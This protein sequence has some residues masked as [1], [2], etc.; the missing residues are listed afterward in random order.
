M[1][2]FT[3]SNLLRW[4]KKRNKTKMLRL[5]WNLSCNIRSTHEHHNPKHNRIV[6]TRPANR[7]HRQMT[8]CVWVGMSFFRLFLEA[9]FFHCVLYWCQMEMTMTVGFRLFTDFL[10]FNRLY[11][12]LSLDRR[13]TKKKKNK[14]QRNVNYS[15]A[16]NERYS[17][18]IAHWATVKFP[19]Y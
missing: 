3:G 8:I 1:F 10:W 16:L 9:F 7:R 19:D 11:D 17:L 15:A 6:K 14:T 4:K 5:L 2:H 18:A 13:K 12:S